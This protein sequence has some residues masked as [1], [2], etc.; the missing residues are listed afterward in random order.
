MPSQSKIVLSKLNTEGK[1]PPIV[2][3]YHEKRRLWWHLSNR[4]AEA[5]TANVGVFESEENEPNHNIKEMGY[6]PE[7]VKF[8]ILPSFSTRFVQ[9]CCKQPFLSY[10]RMLEKFLKGQSSALFLENCIMANFY[11]PEVAFL[12]R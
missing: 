7:A 12:N 11:L 9:V 10:H 2:K 3:T 1:L 6:S 8:T 4:S 5:G